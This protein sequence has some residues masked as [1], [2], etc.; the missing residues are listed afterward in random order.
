MKKSDTRV[1][2]REYGRKRTAG[3]LAPPRD[4]LPRPAGQ[5]QPADGPAQLP[6]DF[7]QR[8]EYMAHMSVAPVTVL[9]A[10]DIILAQ[11]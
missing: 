10:D 2:T 5:R 6:Q 7:G 3:R 11:I 4:K 9:E 1:P 8:T